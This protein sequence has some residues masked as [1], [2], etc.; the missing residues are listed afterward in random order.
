MTIINCRCK[1]CNKIISIL[2]DEKDPRFKVKSG[3]LFTNKSHSNCTSVVND[4]KIM[5]DYVSSSRSMS[6]DAVDF[7]VVKLGEKMVNVTKDEFIR[8]LKGK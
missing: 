8:E 7:I 4:G 3:F 2:V 5:A 1:K 6:E